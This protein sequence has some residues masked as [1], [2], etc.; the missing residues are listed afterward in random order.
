MSS[1]K[2]DASELMLS[3]LAE[4]LYWLGR[5][6]ERA[7]NTAR[8]VSVHD[9]LMLDR[10][11]EAVVSDESEWRPLLEIT[12]SD[13]D[14][15]AL[16]GAKAS[17]DEAAVLRFLLTE[18]K[19]P[20]SM[21][22]SIE[23]ARENAR[24]L[25]ALLPR[26]AWEAI[27]EMTLATRVSCQGGLPRRSRDAFLKTTIRHCQTLV[28]LLDG[29]TNHDA[30][31]RFLV[32]GRMLERADMTTRI[33]DVY[34]RTALETSNDGDENNHWVPV[35]RSLAAYQM[36]RQR[37]QARVR[38]ADALDFL[39]RDRVFP[40]SCVFC[41]DS[42]DEALSRLPN[43]QNAR[44]VISRTA[45]ILAKAQIESIAKDPRAMSKFVDRIQIELAKVHTSLA[46]T[47]FLT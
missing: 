8:L 45:R 19:N 5:Y 9:H 13:E 32:L 20:G 33:I 41:L 21:L 7:E 23:A 2:H 37:R 42:A 18:P 6:V 25:R 16:F 27:N 11:L 24:V 40:R 31:Y 12:G 4:N 38:R 28:G 36:Y 44:T 43:P 10:S 1:R 34:S 39:L 15:S 35:L 29:T 26:E 14:F 3:R 22:S 17:Y 47:W 46:S 30:G